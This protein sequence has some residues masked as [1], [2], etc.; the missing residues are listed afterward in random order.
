MALRKG[1]GQSIA[2]LQKAELISSGLL[3]GCCSPE[4]GITGRIG[5]FQTGLPPLQGRDQS[6]ETH[7]QAAWR[8]DRRCAD[9]STAL[10]IAE[11][12]QI[13]MHHHR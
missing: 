10:L 7:G 11:N 9:R 12:Q 2:F 1:S 8:A 13:A 5:T 4:L 3:K 6:A